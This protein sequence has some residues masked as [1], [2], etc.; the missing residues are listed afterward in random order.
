MAG[1]VIICVWIAPTLIYLST[2]TK[3][4]RPNIQISKSAYDHHTFH[5]RGISRVSYETS[6]DSPHNATAL[7]ILGIRK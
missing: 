4:T 7:F 1:L 2:N 6:L 5:M 3:L